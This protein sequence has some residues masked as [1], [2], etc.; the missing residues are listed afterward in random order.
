MFS[1]AVTVLTGELQFEV[2][3]RR[4]R[5]RPLDAI[6]LPA[7][8]PHMATNISASVDCVCHVAFASDAPGRE[9]C[10]STFKTVKIGD[11]VAP[12]GVPEFV[13]RID[14]VEKY[15]LA[16]DAMFQDLFSSKTGSKGI[17][18]G[19]GVFQPGTSLPCHVHKYDE[20]ITIVSGAAICEAAGNRYTL[21]GCD[22]A[23]VPEGMPH[24]FLNESNAPMA[25]IWVYAGGDPE[26]TL[27]DAG[28]CTGALKMK[29]TN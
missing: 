7:N 21:S 13:S 25:M 4:Y 22:T 11:G 14:R 16:P 23:S 29:T 8:V 24:R 10:H 2:E 26:R 17:C 6:H 12:A 1:E 27:V 5:L 18:G 15:A 20:S 19:Y 3:G 9:L 28:Y